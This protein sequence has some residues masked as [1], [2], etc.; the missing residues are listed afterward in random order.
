[1]SKNKEDMTT[2][3]RIRFDPDF[4]VSSKY[5]NSLKKVLK[6][7][8]DGVP[9]NLIARMLDSTEEEVEKIYQRAIRKLKKIL[10]E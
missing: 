8:P 1:M 6:E 7:Y 3:E 10:G 9:E 4:V 5:D 2:E